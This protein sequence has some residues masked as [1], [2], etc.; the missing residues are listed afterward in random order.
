M[1]PGVRV[2]L[3]VLAMLTI[4]AP[5]CSSRHG[6]TSTQTG[7]APLIAWRDA[8]VPAL[9][10]SSVRSAPPCRASQL[11]ADGRGFTFQAAV[12]GATGSATLRNVSA[13]ACRLTG[14][15]D[16]RFV[17]APKSPAQRRIPLPAQQPDFPQL[18]RP[19]SWLLSLL[20]GGSATLGIEWRNWCVPNARA[21]GK[22][23]PPTAVR[24]TLA[25]GRGSLDVPYNAVTACLHPGE[26]STV[27]VRPFQPPLLAPSRP[28]T[29]EV[30]R[31][32]V[33]TLTGGAGVLRARRGE[34]LRYGVAI[35]NEGDHTV[36]FD[37]CPI[38][39]ELLAPAGR[40]DGHM[41][42]CTAAHP[43][44]PGATERFE[45]RIKVP[46]NAPLGPNGLFW[47]LDPLGAQSP[48]AVARVIVSH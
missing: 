25:R 7:A 4:A 14:R 40:A 33:L 21:S 47:E 43:L 10:T 37:R 35:S 22:L 31:A 11:R 8:P 32:K 29:Q 45:M 38:V 42:N 24:V 20:P 5:G 34:L 23:V 9:R 3:V 15:P 27:G 28:W 2:S 26:P 19:S 36:R 12:A 39:E 1:M 17:G 18:V 46:A 41:L 44:A 16:V 30:L 13:R 6:R 48:E